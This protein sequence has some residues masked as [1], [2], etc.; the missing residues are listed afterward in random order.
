M[1]W[2]RN[3]N[4]KKERRNRNWRYEVSWIASRSHVKEAADETKFRYY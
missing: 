3:V 1:F 4:D 2:K